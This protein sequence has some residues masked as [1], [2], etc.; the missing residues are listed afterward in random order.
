MLRDNPVYILGLS[1]EGMGDLSELGKSILHAADV[2]YGRPDI[3]HQL[4]ELPIKFPIRSPLEPLAQHLRDHS[5]EKRVVLATG[6]PNFF[7]IAE[8]LYRSLGQNFVEVIPHL[9]SMQRA[10]AKI[11]MS[12]H[13]AYFGS[14]HGRSME[15]V[16]FWVLHH[17]KVAILTDPIHNAQRIAQVLVEHGL[18]EARMFV[19]ENLGMETEEISEAAASE[20][21]Y[22]QKGGYAVI[23]I[24]NRLENPKSFGLD[25]QDF[26]RRL[27]QRGMITKKPVRAVAIA[28]L[29]L[30]RESVLWDIGAGTGAV[31]IDASRI[32]GVEG[33][34]FAIERDSRTFEILCA[35]IRHHQAPVQPVMGEAPRI[36]NTLPDP[37]AVFIG[38]SGGFLPEVVKEVLH[39]LRPGGVMVANL[40]AFDRIA[41][42][43]GLIPKDC[44]WNVRLIQTSLMEWEMPVPRFVPDNPVFVVTVKKLKDMIKR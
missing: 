41:S 24:L 28:Q 32:I 27:D 15:M 4:P 43:G 6:D 26:E 44:S 38:G 40:V 3:L 35:N 11:K 19:C 37:H 25:D 20:V 10:F 42:V 8:F 14:V 21:Q 31:G 30:S 13:D 36:L 22:W 2:I 18:G 16:A 34:V 5:L 9:S 29:S 39:R 12:W 23:V 17:S 7:G 33:K 1:P